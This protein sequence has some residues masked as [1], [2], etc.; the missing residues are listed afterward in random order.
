MKSSH[1][2]ISNKEGHVAT[3]EEKTHIWKV[4]FFFFFLME[5]QIKFIIDN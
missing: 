2:A 3:L 1:M 5:D 4:F